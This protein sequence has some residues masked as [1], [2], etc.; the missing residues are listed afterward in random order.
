MASNDKLDDAD[1]VLNIETRLQLKL[2]LAGK[3]EGVFEAP[4]KLLEQPFTLALSAPL[5][6]FCDLAV[7]IGYYFAGL[8]EHVYQRLIHGE[9]SSQVI[10]TGGNDSLYSTNG[11]FQ[12]RSLLRRGANMS[13]KFS[14]PAKM[15]SSSRRFVPATLCGLL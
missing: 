10:M 11:V 8:F 3:V 13:H 14:A 9:G 12:E 6:F 2:F 7:R 5:L 4:A 15:V 1:A